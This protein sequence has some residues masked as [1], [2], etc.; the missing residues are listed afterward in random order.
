[1][2]TAKD[3]TRYII[4]KINTSGSQPPSNVLNMYVTASALTTR[5]AVC[6]VS[7]AFI[8]QVP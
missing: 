6:I 5:K 4:A 2:S 8:D 7:V 3:S 1:M